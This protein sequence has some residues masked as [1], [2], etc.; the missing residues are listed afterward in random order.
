MI[1]VHLQFWPQQCKIEKA[2]NFTHSISKS[3]TS[4]KLKMCKF[5]KLLR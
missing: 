5:T 3:P 1:L 2:I 4:V